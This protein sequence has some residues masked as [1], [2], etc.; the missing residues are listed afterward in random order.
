MKKKPSGEEIRR[1][2]PRLTMSLIMAIIFWIIGIIVPPMVSEVGLPG[3]N[4]DADFL[5][6]SVTM[7]VTA[8]F[9]IRALADALTLADIVTDIIVKRLGIKEERSPR[10]AARD[11]LYIIIVILIV[12]ALSPVLGTL[13]DLGELLTTITT[14]VGLGLIIILV[15]DMGRILYRIIEQRAESVA[16]RLVRMADQDTQSE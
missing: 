3:L 2:I 9:L 1:R 5:L 12:T 11:L 4:L 8:I 15:Y 13:G 10:R 7:L 6:A 14:L 16:D